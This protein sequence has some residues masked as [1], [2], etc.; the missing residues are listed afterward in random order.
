MHYLF[1]PILRFFTPRQRIWNLAYRQL[2]AAF[3]K[4]DN[5]RLHIVDHLHLIP[6]AR[7]RTG[8][9]LGLAEY[10]YS[11]GLIAAQIGEHLH[12]PNPQVLDLGCGTG[13]LVSAVYPFL[14]E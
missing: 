7:H 13:K 5:Q 4:F 14:G 2:D 8:G 12:T 3:R 11:A 9:Q 1:A 10:G 6:P